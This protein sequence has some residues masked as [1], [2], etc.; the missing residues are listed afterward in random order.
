VKFSSFD[1][2][3]EMY[4][5]MLLSSGALAENALEGA[6]ESLFKVGTTHNNNLVL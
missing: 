3:L 6:M 4:D 1:H 5:E 2:F